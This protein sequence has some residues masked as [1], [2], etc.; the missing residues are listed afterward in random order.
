[1][2]L[3]IYIIPISPPFLLLLAAYTNQQTLTFLPKINKAEMIPYLLNVLIF[4]K[5]FKKKFY[6]KCSLNSILNK[7]GDDLEKQ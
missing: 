3:V 6:I 2:T 4:N 1:M 5:T 7:A